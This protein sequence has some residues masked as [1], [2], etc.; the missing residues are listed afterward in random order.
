MDGGVAQVAVLKVVDSTT[1][2]KV[3]S[4]A[5]LNA[6]LTAAQIASSLGP[7]IVI[8]PKTDLVPAPLHAVTIVVLIAVAAA[9]MARV[10]KV[11]ADSAMALHTTVTVG[12]PSGMILTRLRVLPS[13]AAHAAITVAVMYGAQTVAVRVVSPVLAVRTKFQGATV[14]ATRQI[15]PR[16]VTV[17]TMH[18]Q[19][20][21]ATTG[22]TTLPVEA[23]VLKR[24]LDRVVVAQAVESGQGPAG[25]VT[26]GLQYRL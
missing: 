18:V 5:V 10:L 15:G 6:V 19:T 9:Q 26:N 21:I 7:V 1:G 17:A 11:V 22:P 16:A 2:R 8:L 12:P 14:E 24:L 20:D 25:P 23:A 3:G 4:M 13:V